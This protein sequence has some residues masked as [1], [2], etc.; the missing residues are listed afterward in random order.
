MP[1]VC[2]SLGGIV[3]IYFKISSAFLKDCA[4]QVWGIAVKIGI[5]Q[6]R[7]AVK[8]VVVHVLD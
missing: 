7:A 8:S 3:I 2:K 1:W 4:A 6:N 5:R